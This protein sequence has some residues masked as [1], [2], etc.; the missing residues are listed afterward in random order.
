MDQT[1]INARSGRIEHEVVATAET[2]D[3][4]VSARDNDHTHPGPR[5]LG[6][7]A[8]YVLDHAPCAVL[9]VWPDT[10]FR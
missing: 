8:R 5:S 6:P 4:L 9:L 3:L 10:C 1:S 7:T 2:M